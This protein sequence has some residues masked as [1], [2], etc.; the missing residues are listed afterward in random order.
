ASLA[1]YVRTMHREMHGG[2]P[3]F[4]VIPDTPEQVAQYLL[5]LEG[6]ETAKYVDFTGSAANIVVRHNVTSSAEVSYLLAGIDRFMA[7]T[8]PRNVRVRATGETILV[9][10]A[11][12]YMALNEFTS[13]GSTLAIIGII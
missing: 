4:E 10:H 3:A 8:F 7:T 1:D 11:A 9:N 13:F 5:L 6:K 2:D 12:D